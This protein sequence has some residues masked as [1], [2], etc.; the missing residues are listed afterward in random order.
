MK[1]IVQRVKRASVS[2]DNKIVNKIE[3]GF[4][5]LVGFT[6]N[7]TIDDI[8]YMVKKIINLRIFNDEN[9]LMNRNILDV[10]GNILSISQFTLYANC[11]KGNRPSFVDAMQPNKAKELYLKFNEEL[12]KCVKTYDGIFGADMKIDLINDGPV[13]IILESKK[14][15]N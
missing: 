15:V 8:N 7:D 10:N 11:Q 13:T 6:H 3:N 12:N 2:V 9:D 1:V 14:T 4:L 5:L